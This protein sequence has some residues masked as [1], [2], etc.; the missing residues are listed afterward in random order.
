MTLAKR[1]AKL[2]VKKPEDG[3]DLPERKAQEFGDRTAEDR[4]QIKSSLVQAY[5]I[6][7]YMKC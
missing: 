4:K 5:R 7:V 2:L 1:M 6:L 3:F